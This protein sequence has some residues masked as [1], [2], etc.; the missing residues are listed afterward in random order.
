MKE[1]EV[2]VTKY[3]AEDGT[4]FDDKESCEK[5][6]AENK[7]LSDSA[8]ERINL[9]R[10]KRKA[11]DDEAAE[12]ERQQ[13]EKLKSLVG[14]VESI[15]QRIKALCEVGQALYDNKLLSGAKSRAAYPNSFCMWVCGDVFY[16]GTSVVRI[17]TDAYFLTNGVRDFFD[18]HTEVKREEKISLLERFL[19]NFD[20]FE[21]SFY[22]F[23]DETM[24]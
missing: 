6:D 3:V 1:I 19:K 17:V 9:I 18:A 24:K 2:K 23:V 12:F 5:H 13:E 21:N 7:R 8:S 22:A 11:L 4:Q 20:K 16:I 10:A 14:M 15:H